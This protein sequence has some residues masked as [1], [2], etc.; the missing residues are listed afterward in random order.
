[1]RIDNSINTNSYSN[2][3]SSNKLDPSQQNQPETILLQKTGSQEKAP[4]ASYFENLNNLGV[5]FLA[6]K[7]KQATTSPKQNA[8]TN[9]IN[10]TQKEEPKQNGSQVAAKSASGGKVNSEELNTDSWAD[11]GGKV[12]PNQNEY[13]K[14]VLDAVNDPKNP[15]PGFSPKV[16][17]SIIAQESGFDPK[18]NDGKGF[19]GLTQMNET[20]AKSEGKLSFADG[21]PRTQPDKIIPA[22]LRVLTAKAKALD[23]G[24][25][26]KGKGGEVVKLRGF[27]Y[28]G[29]PKEQDKVKFALAAHNVGQGKVLQAL[30]SA[31]GDNAPKEVKYEDV[32]KFLRPLTQ[33]YVKEI[34]QRA[35]KN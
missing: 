9:S 31:Y 26:I 17:K 30:K 8:N 2:D 27:N 15:W 22:T 18:A 6:F 3:V 23:V 35:E 14:R 34:F 29:Q 28:Y 5:N 21:D 33:N 20:T 11:K 13:N 12:F 24:A 16:L 4:S 32:E 1:M 7:L 25:T 10:A 19:V